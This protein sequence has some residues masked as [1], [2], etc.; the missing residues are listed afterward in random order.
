MYQVIVAVVDVPGSEAAARHAL[1]LGRWLGCRVV[2]LALTSGSEAQ[3]QAT[4]RLQQ[5]AA[6]ARRPPRARVCALEG[7]PALEVILEVAQTERANVLL[8]S[9]A[10][11]LAQTLPHSTLPVLL[12][13][14]RPS[15]IPRP[16]AACQPLSPRE[17]F[18]KPAADTPGS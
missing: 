7:R 18:T 17:R 9:A 16:N 11:P 12:L 13:P 1:A 8:V 2:L 5:L 15:G 6:E 10:S 4:E 3:E 14:E